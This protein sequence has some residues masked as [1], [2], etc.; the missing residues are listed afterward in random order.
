MLFAQGNRINVPD[1]FAKIQDAI[2]SSDDGDTIIVAPGTY[3]ENVN[4][5]G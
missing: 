5:Q 3:V 2:N 1:D 4:F